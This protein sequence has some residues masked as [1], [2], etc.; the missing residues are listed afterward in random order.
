MICLEIT[1]TNT[2]KNTNSTI[3]L[4]CG[5]IFHSKCIKKFLKKNYYNKIKCPLCRELICESHDIM[6]DIAIDI[7]EKLDRK[8]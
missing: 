3:Y 8:N 1:D 7:Y 6:Q 2:N 4:D 5:H